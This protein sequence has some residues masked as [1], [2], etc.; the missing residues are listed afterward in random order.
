MRK[1][2]TINHATVSGVFPFGIASSL[3]SS[4][5]M[6]GNHEYRAPVDTETHRRV[7]AKKGGEA[8][9]GGTLAEG[10]GSC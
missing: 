7:V 9:D 2:D 5:F 10:E 8:D 3:V 6:H 4:Q 1:R